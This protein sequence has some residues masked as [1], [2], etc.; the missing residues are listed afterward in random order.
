MSEV[1]SPA[2][3][4]AGPLDGGR[5]AMAR[6]AWAEAFDLLSQ[7]DRER[8][9]SGADLELLAL[10]AFFAAHPDVE[11]DVKERAFKAFL[12][13]GDALRAAYHAIELARE[14]GYTGRRSIASGWIR[15]A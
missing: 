2:S 12:D 15:R 7:A 14:A 11:A 1:S 4:P 3:P 8:P 13:E 10:A 6:R 9:L 5:E